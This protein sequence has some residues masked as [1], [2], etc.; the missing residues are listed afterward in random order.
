M[1]LRNNGKGEGIMFYPKEK[2][3]IDKKIKA[4]AKRGEFTRDDCRDAHFG[5]H[6]IADWQERL[7]A[8]VGNGTLGTLITTTYFR[9]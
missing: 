5:D 9:K 4:I 6:Q 8:L 3:A 1:T 2:G 7:D